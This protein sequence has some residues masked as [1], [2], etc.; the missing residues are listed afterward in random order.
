MTESFVKWRCYDGYLRE[1]SLG[2]TIFR[3]LSIHRNRHEF[4]RPDVFELHD[5][6]AFACELSPSTGLGSIL[7]DGADTGG[8]STRTPRFAGVEN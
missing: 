1:R 4:I 6:V 8:R 5:L 2:L 3:D 7:L